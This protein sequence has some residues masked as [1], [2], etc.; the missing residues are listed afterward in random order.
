MATERARVPAHT[1]G[2]TPVKPGE[3]V[4]VVRVHDASSPDDAVLARLLVNPFAEPD[5]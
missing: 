1:H 3:G 2:A 5:G 4:R